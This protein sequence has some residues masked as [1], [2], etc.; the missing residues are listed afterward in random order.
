MAEEKQ[1]KRGKQNY[2]SSF[3]QAKRDKRRKAAEDRQYKYDRLTTTEKVKLV[4]SRRGESKRELAR[5]EAR[6][7]TEVPAKPAPA[8]EKKTR[9][10]RMKPA[11]K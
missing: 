5:L 10:P 7:A 6:L 1:T 4:K 11:G 8:P 2:N 9:K 3:L